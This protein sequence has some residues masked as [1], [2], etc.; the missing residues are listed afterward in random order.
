MVADA[1]KVQTLLNLAADAAEAIRLQRDILETVRALY[2]TANPNITGT[3]LEGNLAAISTWLDD[4]KAVADD[5]VVDGLIAARVP[6][7]RGKAL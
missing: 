5:P 1:K 4:V 2:V 6:T 7:H 3:P